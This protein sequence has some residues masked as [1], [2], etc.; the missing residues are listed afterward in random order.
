MDFLGQTYTCFLTMRLS[1][2]RVT[3]I[4]EHVLHRQSKQS[5]DVFTN[6]WLKASI[7]PALVLQRH[8]D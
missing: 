1:T 4:F 7:S 6:T 8:I 2:H 3:L 5:Q